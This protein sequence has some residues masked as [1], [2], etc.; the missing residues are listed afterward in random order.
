LFPSPPP[1][2][3]SPVAQIIPRILS[4]TRHLISFCPQAPLRN[5]AKERGWEIPPLT[6]LDEKPKVGSPPTEPEEQRVEIS[7]P[8]P[9]EQRVKP[10]TIT[11]TDQ[12]TGAPLDLGNRSSCPTMVPFAFS[13]PPGRTALPP[14]GD[15]ISYSHVSRRRD[16]LSPPSN[17]TYRA[18][19]PS[20]I[21]RSTESP[22][23]TTHVGK[24]RV[25]PR[26]V[27][28]RGNVTHRI[29][30]QFRVQW[31]PNDGVVSP[32]TWLP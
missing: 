26:V 11:P 9:E 24:W 27:H 32:D 1:S 21:A 15:N 6:A 19:N 4:T 14:G 12:V 29:K 5:P 31:E 28:H 22:Q 8:K 7:A 20:T 13:P 16:A 10:P 2:T 25:L 23:T 3:P 17:D 18:A 30:L